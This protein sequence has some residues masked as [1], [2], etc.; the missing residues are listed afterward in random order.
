MVMKMTIIVMFIMM[1]R[2]MT[3][4]AIRPYCDYNNVELK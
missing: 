3:V 2:I 4:T 1:N